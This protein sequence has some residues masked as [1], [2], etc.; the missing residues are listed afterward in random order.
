MIKVDV[1]YWVTYQ[2]GH[3]TVIMWGVVCGGMI[4]QL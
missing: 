2:F 4:S 3:V 1:T